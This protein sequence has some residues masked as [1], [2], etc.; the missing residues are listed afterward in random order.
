MLKGTPSLNPFLNG[1]LYV[2]HGVQKSTPFG[3]SVFD[4]FSHQET[5]VIGRDSH[6]WRS[7]GAY[8]SSPVAVGGFLF[9]PGENG[10]LYKY[11]IADG[12]YKLHST[13]RYSLTKSKSSPGIESSMAVCRN[14]GYLTDNGGHILCVNLNTLKPVWHYYNHDDT[15]ATPIIGMED[16][17]PYVYSGCE[18]DRQGNTGTSHFVKLNGLTGELVWEALIPCHRIHFGEKALDGGMYGTPLLGERDCDSLIF[19]NF[20][21][22]SACVPGYFTAFNKKDGRIV[23][24]TKTKAYCWSSPVAFYKGDEMYVF[25]ADTNGHVYLI[26]GTTG[27]IVATERIGSN[28]ESSPIVV[29]DKVVM[30]SRGNKIYKISLE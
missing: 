22:N 24:Q 4:L 10:T 18:V 1:Q 23:Y 14:Y 19:A 2:G 7:W 8:D 25:T 30:G 26:K 13:L 15:D 3:T 11:Y 27:E 9:R 12:G 20:C 6:A 29:E 17:V 28:F 5:N 16:G 21:V